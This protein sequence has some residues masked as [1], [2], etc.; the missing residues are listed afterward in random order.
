MMNLDNYYLHATGGYEGYDN[1]LNEILLV[2]RDKKLLTREDRQAN[3]NF[4]CNNNNELC[5]CDPTK[6]NNSNLSLVSSFSRYIERSPALVFPKDL[7]IF[8]PKKCSEEDCWNNTGVTDLYDEV[9]HIGSISLEKIEFVTFPIWPIDYIPD[10]DD[11]HLNIFNTKSKLWHLNIFLD[12]IIEIEKD[13]KTIKMKDI[14]TGVALD[15]SYVKEQ[16]KVYKKTLK[17]R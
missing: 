5:F 1:H 16:I 2:L 15:S 17:N 7:D 9:R 10:Y 8:V 11:V 12:N 4:G 13:F 6:K 14:Y 3:I